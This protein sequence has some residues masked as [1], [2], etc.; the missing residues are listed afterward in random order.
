MLRW[1]PSRYVAL[2]PVV[3]A[4]GCVTHP[5]A[6]EYNLAYVAMEAARSVQAVRYAPALWSQAEQEYRQGEE[7][8]R[9]EDYK[10]AER[11]FIRARDLAERA[12]NLTR[13]KRFETGE[14]VL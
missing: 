10:K 11:A 12:E 14:G 1:A 8:L 3:L 13:A 2:I 5:P 9:Q 7:M 6:T 4:L